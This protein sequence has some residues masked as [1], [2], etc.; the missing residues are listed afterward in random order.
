MKSLKKERIIENQEIFD[1]ELSA[2]DME[3]I[4]SL[5]EGIRTCPDPEVNNF[6]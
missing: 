1:F 6:R 3:R 5:N 4:L 2:E